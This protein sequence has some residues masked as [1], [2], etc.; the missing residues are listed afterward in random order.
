VAQPLVTWVLAVHVFAL[1]AVATTLA[2][3]IAAL[4]TGTGAWMVSAIH[5]RDPAV[6]ARV[7]LASTI[8]SLATLTLL[9]GVL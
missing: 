1:D 6:T 7:L 8:G 3:L 2:V 5:A 4:P 9:L